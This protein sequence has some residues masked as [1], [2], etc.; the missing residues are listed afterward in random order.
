MTVGSRQLAKGEAFPGP[1]DEK[2]ERGVKAT[3][4]SVE[5][6][7]D[8]K[9][10]LVGDVALLEPGEIVPCDDVFVSSHNVKGDKS[11]AAR[12]SPMLSK[13]LAAKIALCSRN[14]QDARVPTFMSLT[15]PTLMPVV[16]RFPAPRSS[17][18]MASAITVGQEGFN[19]RIVTSVCL[20]T[21][22][23]RFPLTES[24]CHDDNRYNR[25]CTDH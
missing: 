22:F 18:G 23:V 3:R 14:G 19:G 11:G 12:R 10:L 20:V 9:E 21:L 15:P 13:R 5:H 2:E 6:I 16:S 4:S 17:K 8:V 25:Y 7:I 1:R 24:L